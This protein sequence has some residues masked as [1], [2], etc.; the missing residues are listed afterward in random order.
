MSARALRLPGA[1]AVL[2]G[3][4]I[5]LRLVFDEYGNTDLQRSFVLNALVSA[6][7][8]A[9]LVVRADRIGPLAGLA[10]TLG[11]LLA[12]A[13]SRTGDGVLDCR[14]TGLDPASEALLALLVEVLAV[15]LLAAVLVVEGREAAAT[16]SRR[17]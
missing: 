8:A 10:V 1:A 12:F 4:A 5:H 14:A 11:S 13:L 9:Y 17:S 6:A 16:S 7:A 3:G 2:I 15:V